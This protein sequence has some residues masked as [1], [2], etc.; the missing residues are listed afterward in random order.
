MQ[1]VVSPLTSQRRPAHLKLPPLMFFKSGNNFLHVAGQRG[2]LDGNALPAPRL[3]VSSCRM[4]SMPR[5]APVSMVSTSSCTCGSGMASRRTGGDMS[6]GNE[7]VVQVVG[8]AAGEPAHAF[9]ALRAE[10]LGLSFFRSVMSLP[11]AIK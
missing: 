1:L 8:N 4:I 6:I 11:M 5:R 2:E 10:E 3:K 9:Q 7:N